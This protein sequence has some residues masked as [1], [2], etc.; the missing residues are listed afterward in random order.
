MAARELHVGDVGTQI[1]VT[2]VDG[3]T[4]VDL[5]TATTIQ[6]FIKK[7]DNTIIT[8]NATL[9]TD[10]TDGKIYYTTISST[11]DQSGY[12]VLQTYVIIGVNKWKSDLYR[13]RVYE[14]I[15]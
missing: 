13:F 11:L 9:Y 5:S 7:P 4:P 1:L 6:Y 15:I 10:G 14:N 8:V 3:S 2:L 12:Y